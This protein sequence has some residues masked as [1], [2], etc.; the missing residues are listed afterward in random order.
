MKS[1]KTNYEAFKEYIVQKAS[2]G[3]SCFDCKARKICK[4]LCEEKGIDST[5]QTPPCLE[6][7]TKWTNMEANK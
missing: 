5:K 1:K 4:A 2:D 7:W 3:S 6:A